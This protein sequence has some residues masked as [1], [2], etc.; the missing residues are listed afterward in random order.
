[1]RRARLCAEAIAASAA[2]FSALDRSLAELSFKK[3]VF[4][5]RPII[6]PSR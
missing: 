6:L 1:V 4:S 5:T 3:P 2:T